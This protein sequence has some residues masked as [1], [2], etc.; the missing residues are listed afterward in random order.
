[1][2][3][4]VLTPQAASRAVVRQTLGVG[5]RQRARKIDNQIRIAKVLSLR[6]ASRNRLEKEDFVAAARLLGRGVDPAA[7]HAVSDVET[8]KHSPGG[9]TEDGRLIPLLE[10]HV[11]SRNSHHAFDVSHPH[12]SYPKWVRYLRGATPPKGWDV[13]PYRLTYREMWGVFAFQAELH[14]DAALCGM[15][16]GRF[17]QLGEGWKRL[18]FDSPLHLVETLYQGEQAQLAVFCRYVIAHGLVGALKAKN[19]RAFAAGYN[20]SGQITRYAV[21]MQEAFLT[22]RVHYYA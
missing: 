14:F 22:R 17:Q 18:G 3:L 20:G 7:V 8:A 12:L 13:H 19:W 2:T 15:S 1:M 16:Y 9:A 4:A 10:P 21:L 5:D 6:V 11:F